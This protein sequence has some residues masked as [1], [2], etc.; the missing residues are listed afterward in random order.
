MNAEKEMMQDLHML[1]DMHH[2]AHEG[3]RAYLE[4]P[5]NPPH[6]PNALYGHSKMV[7]NAILRVH[8]DKKYSDAMAYSLTVDVITMVLLTG[9]KVGEAGIKLDDLTGCECHKVGD[10]EVT[11]EAFEKLMGDTRKGDM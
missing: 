8:G 6:L 4:N 2:H 11:M 10:E 1:T 7:T 9:M 3:V 5:D